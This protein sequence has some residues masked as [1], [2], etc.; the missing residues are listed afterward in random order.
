MLCV[1]IVRMMS[2]SINISGYGGYVLV[3]LVSG[4]RERVLGLGWILF[5]I[6]FCWCLDVVVLGSW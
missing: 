3:G 5:G 2:S 6:L 1:N 4:M